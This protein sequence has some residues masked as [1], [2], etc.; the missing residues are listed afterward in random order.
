M[1]FF[2]YCPLRKY[3]NGRNF[4]AYFQNF[5]RFFMRIQQKIFSMFCVNSPLSDLVFKKKEHNSKQNAKKIKG[6]KSEIIIFQWRRIENKIVKSKS[7][8]A[9]ICDIWNGAGGCALRGTTTYT[10]SIE[11]RATARREEFFE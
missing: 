5:L 8:F 6:G 10:M 9:I 3:V 11:R 4:F 1:F 7:C 2:T